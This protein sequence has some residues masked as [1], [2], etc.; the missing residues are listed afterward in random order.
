MIDGLFAF[1]KCKFFSSVH[2]AVFI[3]GF[4]FLFQAMQVMHR[5]EVEK[6]R[7]K[8]TT[9]QMVKRTKRSAASSPK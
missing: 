3:A 1:V 6:V 8:M 4:L 9:S 5:L 7:V 2:K